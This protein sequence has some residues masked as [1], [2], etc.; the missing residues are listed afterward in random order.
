MESKAEMFYSGLSQEYEP[1]IRQ[2]VPRYDEMADVL[3]HLLAVSDP[4]GILDLGCGP[5]GLE[6]R[7][8]DL[9]PEAEITAVEASKEMVELAGLR[10]GTSATKAPGAGVHLVHT[11]IMGFEPTSRF[12]A[13]FSNLVLHNLDPDLRTILLERVFRWLG[14]GGVFI[15]GD[16]V[17][18]EDREM[19]RYFVDERVAFARSSGCPEDL[20]MENFGKE[21]KDDAPWTVEETL[22]AVRGAGFESAD[23]VWGHDTFALFFCRKGVGSG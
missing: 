18:F 4:K 23:L 15:W 13:V 16:L 3:L 6:F 2:L 19:Q 12:E 8:L 9:L 7:L 10:L 14:E 5:G 21:A 17:R 1:K 11:D 22:A 20:L